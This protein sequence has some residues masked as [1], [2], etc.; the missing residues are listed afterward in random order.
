MKKNYIL[1]KDCICIDT[2]YK[3]NDYD[4]PVVTF[5]GINSN[6]RIVLFGMEFF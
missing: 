4:F 5:C 6:G 2:T 1:F 3:T